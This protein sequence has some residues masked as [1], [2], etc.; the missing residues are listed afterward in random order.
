MIHIFTRRRLIRG[1]NQFSDKRADVTRYLALT[2]ESGGEF[3][4]VRLSPESW[5]KSVLKQSQYGEVL[6]FVHG[7]NTPQIDVIHRLKFLRENLKFPGAIIGFDWPTPHFEWWEFTKIRRVYRTAKENLNRLDNTLVTEGLDVIWNA[8]SSITIHTLAHSMGAYAVA[9]ALSFGKTVQ[10]PDGGSRNIKEAIFGAA[11]IDARQM[12]SLG[13][14]AGVM[15]K[16]SERLT[17][18]YSQVDQILDVS[19]RRLNWSSRSGREGL[20]PEI[21]AGFHDVSVHD[22]YERVLRPSQ[23][24]TG[25]SHSWYLDDPIFLADVDQILAGIDAKLITTREKS[26]NG[27]QRLKLD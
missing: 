16:R 13:G 20:A 17:H 24:G 6:L 19:D 25:P 3:K 9:R 5:A 8:D 12:S 2:E 26:D 18:F 14:F 22:R 23:R 11:D 15:S 1:T 10:S 4:G 21:P 7:F 27:D